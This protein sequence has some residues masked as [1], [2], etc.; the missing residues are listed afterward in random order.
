MTT[1]HVYDQCP[2]PTVAT[3]LGEFESH[4]HYPLG[5]HGWFHISHGSDYTRFFRA[6]G[7]ARSFVAQREGKVT[8]VI[9]VAR[10]T[11]RGPDSTTIEAAYLADLKIAATAGGR[12]LLRLLRESVAWARRTPTTPGFSIVMD[13]TPQSPI[14]YTGRLGIPAYCELCKLM[15]LRIPCLESP[16]PSVATRS[17]LHDVQLRH[18]TLT[19]DRFATSGGDCSQRSQLQPIG[20]INSDGNGCGIIED[21]RRCKLLY[22]DD[23]NEMISAHLSCFGYRTPEDAVQLLQAATHHCW[24]V[25]MPALFVSVPRQECD[26]IVK[27]L[28]QND[29]VKAPATV[30]GH[31]FPEHSIWSVNTSEI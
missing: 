19:E 16:T 6:M 4:F 18:R 28:G 17:S 12:T 8:G 21:T 29:I 7:E 25:D 30:F 2:A 3:A 23:G 27:L 24:Q 14:S 26:N 9:S 1:I 15:I 5:Q 22:R 13:G 11:L 20:L 10:P 31:G